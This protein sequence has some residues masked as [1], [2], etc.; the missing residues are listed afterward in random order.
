MNAQ[1][2]EALYYPISIIII[3]YYSNIDFYR[4][5]LIE[6]YK[7]I[8][9]EFLPLTNK[10]SGNLTFNNYLNNNNNIKNKIN[11][12]QKLEFLNYLHFCTELLRPPNKSI[13]VI[14][15]RFNSLEYKLN[16]LQEIPNN[17]FCIELLFNALEISAIIKLFT[18]L[19]FEKHIIIISNQNLPL[20]CIAEALKLL[21]FPLKWPHIYIPNLP[22]DQIKYLESP[23][24]YLMGINS[25][26]IDIQNLIEQFPSNIICDVNTSTL[27]GNLSNLNLPTKEEIRI[28]SNLL[29]LKSK[30][31]NNY[32]EFDYNS[33]QKLSET[34]NSNSNSN[35][36]ENEDINFQ[37][38]FSQN[39]QNIFFE[40]FRNNLANIKNEYFSGNIFNSHKFLDSFKEPE[41]K[42][43]FEKLINTL[44][45]ED[46]LISLQYY[47]DSFSRQYNKI[48]NEHEKIQ[49]KKNKYYIYEFKIQKSIKENSFNQNEILI[50][51]INDYNE[52]SDTIEKNNKKNNNNY[53]NDN[54]NIIKKRYNSVKHLNDKFLKS[55]LYRATINSIKEKDYQKYIFLNFYGKD[56]FITFYKKYNYFFLYNKIIY[57]E[58]NQIYEEISSSYACNSEYKMVP[59]NM[60]SNNINKEIKDLENEEEQEKLIEIPINYSSQLYILISLYLCHYI[61]YEKNNPNINNNQIFDNRNTEINLNINLNI[62]NFSNENNHSNGEIKNEEKNLNIDNEISYKKNKNIKNHTYI[63]KLFIHAFRKDQHEFPRNI[64]YTL[65]NLFSLEELKKI[66]KTNI[67]YIDKTIQYRIDNIEKITYKSMVI[68]MDSDID[69]ISEE[70][71]QI[72][73]LN[74]HKLSDDFDDIKLLEILNKN[75]HNKNNFNNMS[76]S[77]KENEEEQN[78]QKTKINVIE[79]SNYHSYLSNTANNNKE[80][81]QYKKKISKF[82]ISKINFKDLP[83][84]RKC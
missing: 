35:S 13:F 9:L 4:K 68:N 30:N 29:K 6:F 12:F 71:Q 62:N 15:M 50:K 17:D 11:T 8:K 24:P 34:N 45:F 37:I 52:I 53:F 76:L 32:D 7:I 51:L 16:S 42:Y 10:N 41:Y 19:L 81:N 75:T 66:E 33:S 21:L 72:R 49:D 38:S 27:Y 28:K 78:F 59:I 69:E 36:D 40:L 47:D 18:A 2:N 48:I 60:S 3:S 84:H 61:E 64:F 5:L 23:T 14:N 22:Y 46:F 1:K 43:F 80:K 79:H 44:I 65:L 26:L 55:D 39:V 58:I 77:T 31:K 54:K 73:Q 83:N 70:D 57:K 20:F 25:P 74:T 56:N 67:K 63:I 82:N